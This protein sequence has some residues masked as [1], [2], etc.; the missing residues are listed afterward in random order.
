MADSIKKPVRGPT[1]VVYC[2][3]DSA[4]L[5]SYSEWQLATPGNKP[6]PKD[7]PPKPP[8][9][10]VPL[11]EYSHWPVNK[12][13]IYRVTILRFTLRSERRAE[14]A[15]E[16]DEARS[17]LRFCFGSL[18]FSPRGLPA[19]RITAI[20][21]IQLDRNGET[22]VRQFVVYGDRLVVDEET[23]LYY[24]ASPGFRTLLASL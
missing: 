7:G 5:Q 4:Y 15:F 1:G 3:P 8:D 14:L 17:I 12:D 11:K 23:K 13:K 18:G 10:V 16:G 22:V 20:V 2:G 9:L 6:V 21:K 24:Y 19:A